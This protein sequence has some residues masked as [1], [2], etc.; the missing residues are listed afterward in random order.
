LRHAA[1]VSVRTDKF[2][3][4]VRREPIA[5]ESGHTRLNRNL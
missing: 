2:A 4:D 5:G 3:R 1:F